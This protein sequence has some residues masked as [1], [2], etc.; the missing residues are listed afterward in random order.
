[1]ILYHATM[2]LDPIEEFIPRIPINRFI[3]EDETTPRVCL[4]SS[5]SG[6]LTAAP[7]GGSKL[8]ENIYLSN[9]SNRL[10]RVYEFD[11]TLIREENI[12][13]PEYLYKNDIVR[14]AEITGEHWVT[15]AIKPTNSYIMKLT[16]Y[17]DDYGDDNIE[18]KYIK[19]F[20]DGEIEDISPYIEGFV[21][22]IDEI[23]FDIIPEERRSKIIELNNEI[24]YKQDNQNKNIINLILDEFPYSS[25]TYLD[26]HKIEGKNY[27]YGV[28]DT[29]GGE[30]DLLE[31]MEVINDIVPDVVEIM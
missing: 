18:Y 14:D 24:N 11:A 20:E 8:T 28:I 26:I 31:V 1:M 17:S 21:T 12:I 30:I 2:N 19:M 10:I 9:G 3:G 7:F 15:V 6:C 22:V 5:I 16:R 29:R 23:K 27:L 4:S 13:G 25:K